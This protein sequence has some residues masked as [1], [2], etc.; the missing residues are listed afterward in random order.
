MTKNES[1]VHRAAG[2][3]IL[4]TGLFTL[5]TLAALQTRAEAPAESTAS[6]YLW[7]C[8][9]DGYDHN[10]QLRS[11]SGPNRNT[12]REARDAAVRQ[13]QSLGW[14]GCQSRSCFQ[15]GT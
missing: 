7:W 2:T 11:T 3:L 9:A 1:R 5:S 15:T 13:C 6:R 8:T 10:N 14:M 12:E 4:L